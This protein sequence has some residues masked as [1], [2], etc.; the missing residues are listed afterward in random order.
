MMRTVMYNYETR[1]LLFRAL[2]L[3]EIALGRTS[4]D[5]LGP[6]CFSTKPQTPLL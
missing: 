3:K 2:K 5:Y 4:N 1:G 6:S